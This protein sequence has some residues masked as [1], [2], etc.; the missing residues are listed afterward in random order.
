MRM[1]LL[2]LLLIMGSK[3]QNLEELYNTGQYTKAINAFDSLQ[4][5]TIADQIFLAKSFCAKGMNEDCV[6]T[7]QKALEHTE[8][9]AHLVAKFNYAKLLQTQKKYKAADSIYQK[10]L[11]NPLSKCTQTQFEIMPFPD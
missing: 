2:F 1:F 11:A 9:N 5:P 10:L 3:A 8:S 4:Q 6:N 7:Y